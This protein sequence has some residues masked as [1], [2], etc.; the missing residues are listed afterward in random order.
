MLKIVR[1][2][3]PMYG[4]GEPVRINNEVA[5]PVAEVVNEETGDTHTREE[6]R[7]MEELRKKEEELRTMEAEHRLELDRRINEE[8]EAKLKQFLARRSESLEKERKEIIDAAKRE[9]NAITADAKSTTMSVIK[10]AESESIKLREEARREGHDQGYSEGRTE[11]LEKYKKYID[12][13]GKLLSEINARKEAY[14]ISGEEEMRETVFDMVRKVIGEELK[15][16]PAII[17]GIIGEAAKTFRNS[18]YIKITLAEDEISERYVTDRKLMR[19]II[20]YIPEI[21]IEFDDEAE[22]GTVIIDNGSEIVDAGIPTQLDFL[23]EILRNTRGENTE[24]EEEFME[25]IKGRTQRRKSITIS[26]D[27]PEPA[28]ADRAVETASDRAAAVA[29]RAME[30]AAEPM[31]VEPEPVVFEPEPEPV[32]KKPAKKAEPKPAKAAKTTRSARSTKTAAKAVEEETAMAEA[33]EA[34]AEMTEA[35]EAAV[36]KSRAAE[37]LDMEEAVNAE[38]EMAEAMEAAAE[39]SQAFEAETEEAFEAAAEIAEAMEAAAEMTEAVEAARKARR[40]EAAAE[41]AEAVNAGVEMAEAMEA[42]SEMA[43][44]VEAAAEAVEAAEA[45]D[46]ATDEMADG[47]ADDV[48][49]NAFEADSDALAEAMAFMESVAEDLA[50]PETAAGISGLTDEEAMEQLKLS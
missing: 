48:A 6:K 30:T 46:G 4:M 15:A 13:A 26:A 25:E 32:V 2:M 10:K 14:Y 16:D 29:D 45:A 23:K 38:V 36:K 40:A 33:M 42:A 9:A 1:G 37:V 44:A 12:A 49:D 31:A 35:V 24:D 50:E 11:S 3:S 19:D 18:D 41:I 34:A 22:T 17:D 21:E 27:D 8:S 47:A 7:L 20:P 43:S 28:V 5:M 39:M